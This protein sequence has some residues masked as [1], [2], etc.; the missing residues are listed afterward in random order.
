MNI[1]IDKYNNGVFYEF[2]LLII[3]DCYFNLILN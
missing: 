3:K 1:V 2:H